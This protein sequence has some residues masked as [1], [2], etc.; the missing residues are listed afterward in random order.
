MDFFFVGYRDPIFGVIV[1]FGVLLLVAVLSYV[2]GILGAKD[3]KHNIE[4]FV[5]KFEKTTGLSDEHKKLLLEL[6]IDVSSLGILAS[7]FS[8]SGDFDKAIS[9]YLIALSKVKDK[10]QREFLLVNLGKI[11]LKAGFLKR[12]SDVF[13]EALKLSPR[14]DEALRFLS[15]VYEK[16]KMYENCL[17]ALD[18]LDEQGAEVGAEVA[19]TKALIVCS[20]KMEFAKKIDEILKLS[21][22]FPL[23]KRVALEQFIKNHEPLSGLKEFPSL[24]QSIDT[25]FWL[26]E[27]VNLGDDEFKA[28]FKAKGLI[29]DEVEIKDFNLSVLNSAKK[30]GINATLSFNFFCNECK[31]TYPLFFYRCPNCARLGSVKISTQVTKESSENDMPF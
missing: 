27:A 6:G 20:Q 22:E 17:E 24:N 31:T 4:K 5:K 1:L 12:A 25:V 7:T 10:K 21:S 8:K 2:W 16:L 9:V 3:E 11:Y 28:L 14:N 23:L 18:A 26:N 13:L 30:S 19:Y 15:V 29:D